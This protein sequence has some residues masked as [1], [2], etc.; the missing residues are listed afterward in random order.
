VGA[1]ERLL[2]KPSAIT[3]AMTVSSQERFRFRKMLSFQ[4]IFGAQREESE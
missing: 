4:H 2:T 1:P 3:K